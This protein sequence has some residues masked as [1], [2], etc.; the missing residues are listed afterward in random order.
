[1][2]SFVFTKLKAEK[3]CNFGI[4]EYFG[5]SQGTKKKQDSSAFFHEVHS[6]I[7]V[8]ATTATV[9]QKTNHL[10]N[11]DGY[12]HESYKKFHPISSATGLKETMLESRAYGD[13]NTY[14]AGIVN[15][16][17]SGMLLC[18]LNKDHLVNEFPI[19]KYHEIK[20]H[21]CGVIADESLRPPSAL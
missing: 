14:P 12:H 11:I 4:Q 18:E 19:N 7:V 2:H 21:V 15:P 16:A 10:P 17:F 3:K 8:D 5:P 13:F 9:N 1:M 6:E 20:F